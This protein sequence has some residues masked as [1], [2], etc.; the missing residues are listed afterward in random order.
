MESSSI[1]QVETGI[2]SNSGVMCVQEK[3]G[4]GEG[5]VGSIYDCL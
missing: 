5:G 1:E 4:L 3:G 2:S